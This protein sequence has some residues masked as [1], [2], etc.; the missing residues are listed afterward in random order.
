MMRYIKPF[1]I[2]A[3]TLGALVLQSPTGTA[4]SSSAP[5]ET[6]TG[7]RQETRG[8]VHF[9]EK[10]HYAG[11][12]VVEMDH[13]AFIDDYMQNL[14]NHRLLFL[15]ED[16]DTFKE[17]FAPLMPRFLNQ[18]ELYP[19]FV[20]F[21]TYKQRLS[22]RMEWLNQRLEE[23][24]DLGTELSFAPDRSEAT[25]PVDAA[26]TDALWH[27]RLKYELIN[28]IL[29]RI[30]REEKALKNEAA[31]QESGDTPDTIDYTVLNETLD[32]EEVYAEAKD[33]IRER[34]ETM[35]RRIDEME[36]GEV[37]EMFL[38]TLA[39]R[40]DPHSNFLSA[41]S[42]EEFSI[43][44]RNSL[45]G[46]GAVLSD[47]DGYCTIQELLPGGPA[48]RSKEI[49]PGD[50]IVGVGQEKDGEIVDTI[51]MKLRRIVKMI[52]G[53]QGS[54]VRLLI[55]PADGDPSERREILLVRDE[56]KLTA[57]LAKAEVFEVPGEESTIT[58]GVI[59]LPAFYGSGQDDDKSSTTRDVEELIEKLKTFNV[60]G[61]V[62]DLRRNGG[63]LLSEAI[64]L[65][66]L[67]IPVG[68]VVQVRNPLGQVQEYLDND[69]KVVWNGP[70]VVLVSRYSASASEIVAGALKV[71]GRAIVVGDEETHGKGTV[72]AVYEMDRGGFLSALRPQRG[73]AKV[74]VQK[75]YLPDGTST[76]IK[77][78]RSDI[79]LPSI[80]AF[81]PIGESDLPNAMEWDTIDSLEWDYGIDFA[82]RGLAIDESLISQLSLRSQERQETLPEFQHLKKNIEWFRNRQEQKTFSLN[83]EK[84][85]EQ[86]TADVEFRRT[87]RERL[88]EL[89]N[90]NFAS[91]EVLLKVTEEQDA[92]HRAIIAEI[93][94]SEEDSDAGTEGLPEENTVEEEE[95]LPDFDIHLR[96]SLRIMVDWIDLNRR[97][98]IAES[99]ESVAVTDPAPRS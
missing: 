10:I 76:Q 46:I 51:G 73:A 36:P 1:T 98:K 78:V 63:G 29:G 80:N 84:R 61:I 65:T 24:I 79:P 3:L 19:A 21:D 32:W 35:Q 7:M 6:T 72:Q 8:V 11:R 62:L 25:W 44:M 94:S 69:P 2:L 15:Q 96:E 23:R 45:V 34:Y 68:P 91:S 49:K 82:P 74:T 37:Q 30:G 56:I 58:I 50:A 48:E 22:E 31:E 64:D 89:A 27:Q 54:T 26:E 52:R 81:L 40:Y 4:Q 77:G 83:L 28:E 87:I 92:E 86:R 14:D 18:G 12:P 57:N 13:E 66:G 20:I 71:H 17:R 42:L 99:K 5:Y 97:S 39:R 55:R 47:K 95:S 41:D 93:R 43:A 75:Y 59:D 88:L 90:D 33:K 9:L 38:T 70:L 16:A 85:R 53:K 60:E 67:F